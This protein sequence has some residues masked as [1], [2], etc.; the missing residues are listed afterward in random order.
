MQD[1]FLLRQQN[2]QD[3]NCFLFNQHQQYIRHLQTRNAKWCLQTREY[4]SLSEDF[5]EMDVGGESVGFV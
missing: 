4:G 3:I 2:D 5:P 1:W